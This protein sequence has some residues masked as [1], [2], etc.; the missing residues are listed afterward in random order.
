MVAV[1]KGRIDGGVLYEKTENSTG[2]PSTG[3][4]HQGAIKDFASWP[5]AGNAEWP[6]SRPLPLLPGRT[7]RVYGSTHDNE[8]SGLSVEFTVDD[9]AALRVDQ[10][11]Y[12][13]WATPGTTVITSTAEFRAHACDKR[14]KS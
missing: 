13:P 12:T 5:L 7:Y 2:R 14:E 3:W 9:L 1:C 4:R 8:W 6:L 10:V 11:R